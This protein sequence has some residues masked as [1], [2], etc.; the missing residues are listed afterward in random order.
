M[1]TLNHLHLGALKTIY[2]QLYSSHDDQTHLHDFPPSAILECPALLGHFLSAL[3][4]KTGWAY[5]V[6]MGGPDPNA[7]GDICVARYAFQADV[8]S[9]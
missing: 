4:D 5:T 9:V 1:R 2:G 6:L 3:A 8:E 7:N